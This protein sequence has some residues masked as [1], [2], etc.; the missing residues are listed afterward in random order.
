MVEL[1]R[2][3]V[4][5]IGRWRI[6]SEGSTIRIAHCTV[7]GGVEVTHTEE[8]PHGLAG[9]TQQQQIASRIASRV[10]KMRDKGY[11]DTGEEALASNTNQL[12]LARPMLAQPLAKVVNP[13]L[14]GAVLQKKLDGHRCL[15]TCIDGEVVAYS[16]QGKPI[17]AI[18]HIL[19]ALHMQIPE[20]VTLDGELYCHGF[21]LQTLASWIKREQVETYKLSYVCYDL[22]DEELSFKQRHAWLERIIH[23]LPPMEYEGKVLC[24][25]HTPYTNVEDMMALKAKVRSAGFEGLMLRL[26]NRGYEDGKRS[27]SLIKV[28][29]FFDDEFK[30][31]GV[32]ASADGWGIC[33]LR[34]HNGSIFRT[35][36]PGDIAAKRHVLE[37]IEQYV[38]RMLTVEY[39]ALT[40]DGIPFHASA[41]CWR[42]DI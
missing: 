37:N 7:L 14:N 13:S 17:T 15:I 36:A 20:G 26:D 8:V 39:S 30:C 3:N 29:E 42:E 10:S 21:P 11:K 35:S 23:S 19:S 38:G 33:V 34:A 5:G 16:R 32:V 25:P 6:W 2:K 24:L 28:K 40:T 12:G 22:M 31:I 9:R 1:F 4:T 18:K 27:S 41:K